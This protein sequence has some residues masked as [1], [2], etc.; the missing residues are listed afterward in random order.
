MEAVRNP[1]R[2]LL[3]RLCPYRRERFA[4]YPSF[5]RHTA[6]VAQDIPLPRYADSSRAVQ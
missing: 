4:G 5:K 3:L 6:G 1:R 2:N